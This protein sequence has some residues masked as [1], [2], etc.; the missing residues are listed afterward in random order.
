MLAGVRV[1][2]VD[3]GAGA[4]V[5]AASADD[6]LVV[7]DQRSRGQRAKARLHVIKLDRLDQFPGVGLGPVDFAVVGDRNDEVFVERDPADS[8]R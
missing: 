2:G 3:M 8:R 7:D 6:Q 4:L 5:P 1:E